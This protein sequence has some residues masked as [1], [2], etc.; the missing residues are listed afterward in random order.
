MVQCRFEIKSSVVEDL[1]RY[2]QSD[3]NELC[4]VLM[5]SKVGDNTYRISKA[6]PPCVV[7]NT[8]CGCLR[9]ARKANEFLANDYEASEHTRSYIGEWHT[10]PEPNPSPSPT[11]YHSL[12]A[13]YH[14]SQ[15][16]YPF[17]AMIIVG[18]ERFYTSIY[19]GA[20]L[21]ESTFEEN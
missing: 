14:S 7:S 21:I 3:G 2:T 4:G 9:D 12:A 6:S 19:N 8:R 18:T 20:L 15:R 11:D 17:L 10:H 16:A 1:K 5:G 13:N